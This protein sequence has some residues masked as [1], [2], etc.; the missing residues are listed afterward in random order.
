MAYNIHISDIR[1]FRSCRRKW[2]WASPLRN[3]LEPSVPYAPFFVGRAIHHCL[4]HFYRE[5]EHI[6]D[7]LDAFLANEE[8]IA[9]NLW[10]QEQDVWDD[11]VNLIT[12]MLGHYMLWR[13]V[14][15]SDFRDENLEFVELEIPF[16]VPMYN[17]VTGI[18]DL[19]VRLEGRFDGIVKHK[20]TDTYWIWE[21]KTA[22]SIGELAKSLDMD[23]QCGAYIY[24]AEQLR[25]THITGVLYNI[26]RKKA[27][28][29]PRILDNGFL[30]KQKNIDTTPF[31]YIADVRRNHPEADW[32]FIQQFYGEV[33]N[34]MS[35][36]DNGF[37]AR[38]PIR[39]SSYE[40]KMLADNL[41]YTAME[42]IDPK[43]PMYPS[44]TFIQCNFCQFRAPCLAMSR[45]GNYEALLNAEFQKREKAESFRGVENESQV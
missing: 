13:Q 5:G 35:I 8:K 27:P 7:L 19:A 14:D 28:S 36:G 2:D 31:A 3:N 37:F 24:A 20:P 38:F 17:P 40:I 32:A 9:G 15:T 22:R 39:R 41:Y 1:T 33:I 43:T 4:E 26:L 18:A 42:M 45:G 21:T 30:S 44:P 34:G 25:N 11:S 16:N 23:E 6:W 10:K 29:H 12:E